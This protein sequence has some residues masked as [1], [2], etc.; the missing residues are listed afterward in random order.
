[1]RVVV[2]FILSIVLQLYLSFS[3]AQGADH[4]KIETT[5]YVSS[6]NGDDNNDGL[7]AKTPKQHIYAIGKKENVH[8]LLKCGDVFFEQIIS[9]SNSVIESYGQG[10]KPV[11]CGFKVL[12]NPQAWTYDEHEG[13]WKIDLQDE[14]NFAGMKHGDVTDDRINNVGFI[15]DP[16]ADKVYGNRVKLINNLK[17]DGSFYITDLFVTKSLKSDSFRFLRWKINRDPR[18]IKHLCFPM[19]LIGVKNL[20]NCELRNI[21]IVGFNFGVVNCNGTV[22][23]KCQ[24]DLIGGS[25]QLGQQYWVR[26]GNGIEYIWANKD[27]EVKNCLISR[28]YD[29]GVSIQSSG[30]FNGSPKNIHFEGNRFYHCRQ[31]FE[32][33]LNAKN[34]YKPQYLN[35]SFS[36]NICYMM[37][38]N[39]FSNHQLRDANLLSYDGT[40]KSI[41]IEGNLFFGA[42]YFCGAVF[43][44]GLR[45]NTVYVYEGQYL[46]NYHGKRTLPVV[47]AKGKDEIK[48]YR[49]LS[50]DN[51]KIV[52]MQKNSESANRSNSKVKEMIAWKP[53]DLQLDILEKD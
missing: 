20:N 30:K 5:Y 35:C 49:H 40:A 53:A 33:F 38:D 27:N 12:M 9:Y 10:N 23:D 6:S 42:P 32:F 22:V 41:K 29:C 45:K 24:I 44:K 4:G 52:I 15:Y 48:Q 1:M 47:I 37:G 25:V 36:N 8:I 21:A 26:Y 19:W 16:Q 50:G 28:T 31:A 43:P 39:E 51:S 18:D 34:D 46:Y 3:Y 7:S 14:A 17:D 13:L 2:I 11:L